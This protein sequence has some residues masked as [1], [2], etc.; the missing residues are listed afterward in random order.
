MYSP[1]LISEQ[2]W[3][4]LYIERWIV[5]EQIFAP[6][7]KCQWLFTTLQV[8]RSIGK[9]PKKDASLSLQLLARGVNQLLRSKSS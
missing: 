2:M 6:V 9:I 7:G 3:G 8:L 5:T 4:E 1:F